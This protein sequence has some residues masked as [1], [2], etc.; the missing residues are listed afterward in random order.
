MVRTLEKLDLLPAVTRITGISSRD[1][2]KS[3]KKLPW[4]KRFEYSVA[5]YAK[6]E[7]VIEITCV[8]KGEQHKRFHIVHAVNAAARTRRLGE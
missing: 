2:G 4:R 5:I 7:T 1:P 8:L 6:R 3:D